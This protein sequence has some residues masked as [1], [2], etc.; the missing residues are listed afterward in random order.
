MEQ[1]I[2]VLKRGGGFGGKTSSF[3]CYLPYGRAL[4]CAHR[5]EAVLVP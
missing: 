3:P 5:V 1:W 2:G 4:D